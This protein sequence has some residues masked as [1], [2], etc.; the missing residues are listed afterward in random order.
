MTMR[1]PPTGASFSLPTVY[2]ATGTTKSKN[3]Y[4]RHSAGRPGLLAGVLHLLP[5]LAPDRVAPMEEDEVVGVL[6]DGF[7]SWR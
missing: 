3:V 4:G 2:R 7:A 1:T 6:K 5:Q